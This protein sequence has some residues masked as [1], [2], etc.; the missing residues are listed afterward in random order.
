MKTGCDSGEMFVIKW[1]IDVEALLAHGAQVAT[2]AMCMATVGTGVCKRGWPT[3]LQRKPRCYSRFE[4]G[5][6][7]NCVF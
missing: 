5:L 7:Q 4:W 6:R 3:E 1:Y 2:S